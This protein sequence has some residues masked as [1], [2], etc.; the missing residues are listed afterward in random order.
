MFKT[1]DLPILSILRGI[2]K[3]HIVPL[4]EIFISNR[5]RHI[6]ITMNTVGAEELI[7]SMVMQA[8]NDLH[9]GAGTVLNLEEMQRAK[10][11]GA[12]FIVSPA[13]IPNVINTCVQE[14]I[15]VFPGA[16]T[17][18]EIQLAWES[19]ASM[20]KLFPASLFGPEYIKQVKVPLDKIKIIA[21]GGINE[22]N[23]GKYFG[24]G[25]DA[26]AFGSGVVDS[27]LLNAGAYPEIDKRVKR[28]ILAL[29]GTELE[30]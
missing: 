8:G 16:L 21:V 10:K 1:D 17:P 27:E 26:V 11:A 22:K 29:Q 5:I 7:R 12:K 30:S 20:V 6:E 4:T 24:A 25:A 9:I 19:G 23:I 15:P 28:F 2:K 3:E 18:T 13:V 14:G